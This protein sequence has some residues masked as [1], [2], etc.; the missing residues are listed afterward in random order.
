MLRRGFFFF[1]PPCSGPGE[2]E[3]EKLNEVMQEAWKYNRECKLL[4]DT[5]Q[6]FSWNG[7]YHK[8]VQVPRHHKNK[9]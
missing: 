6:T 1:F 5:L 7:E 3:D 4:R 2:N 9:N 8:P